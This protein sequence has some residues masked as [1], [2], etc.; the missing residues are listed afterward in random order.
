M[1]ASRPLRVNADLSDP[2]RADI[3]HPGTTYKKGDAICT[4]LGK[5]RTRGEAADMVRDGVRRAKK[6]LCAPG[7]GTRAHP[8][9]R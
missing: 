1:F 4:Q 9:N 5:G 3:P 8:G 7:P 6:L 2:L